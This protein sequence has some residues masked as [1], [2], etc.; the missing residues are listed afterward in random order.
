MNNSFLRNYL[1][2][3]HTL[4][5]IFRIIAVAI[6]LCSWLL[7]FRTFESNYFV[8]TIF[9]LALFFGVNSFFDRRDKAI[10]KSSSYDDLLNDTSITKD[11]KRTIYYERK[12]LFNRIDN[13]DGYVAFFAWTLAAIL[14]I[15]VPWY[16]GLLKI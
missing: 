8:R 12:D 6:A 15:A 9:L 16:L 13:L 7:I 10:R 2:Y 1:N 5:N 4:N 14:V 11:E 3:S